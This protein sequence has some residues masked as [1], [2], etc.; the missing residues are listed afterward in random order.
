MATNEIWIVM[1]LV[2]TKHSW[3]DG[4]NSRGFECL[5]CDVDGFQLLTAYVVVPDKP[6]LKR[7]SL[8]NCRHITIELRCLTLSNY[9]SIGD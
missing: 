5:F 2:F 7:Q 9:N 1:N 8:G 6:I 4:L 3:F